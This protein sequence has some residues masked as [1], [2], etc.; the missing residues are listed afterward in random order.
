[1]SKFYFFTDPALLDSQ[2][3]A[4]AFGPMGAS[5]GKDLFRVTDLHTS[6]F[7]TVPAIAICDGF[8]CAQ[9]DDQGM[10]TLILKPSVQ[11]P[12]DFPAISYIL[13]KGIDPASLLA[14]D[15]TIDSAQEADSDLISAIK[16]AWELEA[17]GN[18]GSPTRACIGLHLNPA[19][20]PDDE[21]PERFADT[22]PIDR[23][24][25]EGDPAIQLPLVR[26]DWRLG[27]FSTNLPFGIE[28]VVERIGRRP[29]IALAR[30]LENIVEVDALANGA[31]A[32]EVFRHWDAKEA[33][34]DFVD[35]CAFWGSF[36]AAKLRAWNSTNSEFDRLSG[37]EIYETVL[38][39]TAS[40]AAK[41]A[42][43]NRAYIDI[44]NEHGNSL[45]YY[46]AD[47]PNIQLTCDADADI[48]TCEVNYYG[49]G[50]PS[51]GV[52]NSNLPAGSTGGKI[53]VRFGLP[54][55]A[56][57]RPL[58]YISAGYRGEFRRLKDPKRFIDRPRRADAS[59]LEETSITIPIVDD[60]GTKIVSSYQR[61][62]SFK[63][64][65]IVNG[66]AVTA[67]ATDSLA[68]SYAEMLDHVFQVLGKDEFH[69]GDELTVA[70]TYAEERYVTSPT[71]EYGGFTAR[72][73]VAED[74]SNRY[75]LLTPYCYYRWP[76]ATGVFDGASGSPAA[77]ASS[78][79]HFLAHYTKR[80]SP[81]EVQQI[82]VAPPP[83]A[84]TQ[85]P[86]EIAVEGPPRSS[87]R[88]FEG[89]GFGRTVVLCL[90]KIDVDQL[91]SDLA[92][93][94]PIPG[95]IFLLPGPAQFFDEGNRRYIRSSLAAAYIKTSPAVAR[96]VIPTS[97]EIYSDANP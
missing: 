40:G 22:E 73:T 15:G 78:A 63:R 72:L 50:W 44:R 60:A 29:K 13:Y 66:T 32:S 6:S 77:T 24:F 35:P 71:A 37:N 65:L 90:P 42:N 18:T 33:I 76:G 82:A 31:D 75:W 94:T 28:I 27:T 55:T 7:T 14:A 23:F 81:R 62:V 67:P 49:S 48:D 9:T 5:A 79:D 59:Y 51:F 68:P 47:G 21:N 64:P 91:L 80:R 11:P 53:D 61:I 26:A 96:E 1:M 25:Y 12:F 84:A 92:T 85:S 16:S 93:A 8:V 74:A 2:V 46:Q 20:Y 43:R 38:H 70:R 57:T 19:D 39:G 4:Q 89:G 95:S 41:F 88:G 54:K 58:I 97:L 30:K 56:N 45:N 83:G 17:N 36:F 3:A 10:L 87:W 52:D 86:V 34:L 69:L